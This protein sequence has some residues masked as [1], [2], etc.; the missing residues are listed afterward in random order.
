MVRLYQ[1]KNSNIHGGL[2]I[3]EATN[4]NQVE[5]YYVPSR[6]ALDVYN[7]KFKPPIPKKHKVKLLKFNT[8]TG[9]FTI[10]PINTLS[11]NERYLKPKYKQI[12]KITLLNGKPVIAPNYIDSPSDQVFAHTITFEQTVPLDYDINDGDIANIMDS[13]CKSCAF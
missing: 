13:K 7:A 9:R 12:Q 6:S 11:S 1:T 8:T 3:N 4:K 5:V 10:F 2:W